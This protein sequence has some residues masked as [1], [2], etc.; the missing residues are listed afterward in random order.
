MWR[1]DTNHYFCLMDYREFLEHGGDH[2]LPNLSI[3]LVIIGY[4][5]MKLKCLLL[6][7][8]EKW[9]L[10]GGYI[11]KAEAVD[12]AAVRILKERTALENPHLKF[13]S[14][15]GNSDRHFREE[16]KEFVEKSGVPW[17]EDYWFNARFVSLAYYSLVRT[18]STYPVPGRYDQAV[19]WF[20]FEELP[21]MWMDHKEIVLK[22][23]A[24]LKEDVQ[25]EHLT[26]RLLPERF[27]MPEL[28]QLHQ[29]IL[30]ANIDRSRFQ[31]KMLASGRY[32]RLPKLQ[33]D[34]PGRNPYQY[35]VEPEE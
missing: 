8:G 23:R 29:S 21:P 11:G 2:F 32:K 17:K 27:T 14:V 20:P 1:N 24:R 15:F 19:G 28:H 30:Q 33:K 13:L 3:D 31:K 7:I 12:T 16:W 5:D 25:E 26:H 18:G 10:P 35:A 6:Q 4:D 22:A 34:A 9:L